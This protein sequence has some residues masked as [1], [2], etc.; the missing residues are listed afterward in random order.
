[1]LEVI[2]KRYCRNK[3]SLAFTWMQNL[4]KHVYLAM[5]K[6]L[7][8]WKIVCYVGSL[9]PSNRGKILQTEENSNWPDWFES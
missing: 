5:E 4:F 3:A 6:C 8:F 7:K 9:N 1:M 2:E